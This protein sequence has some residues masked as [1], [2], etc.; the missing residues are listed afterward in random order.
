[1]HFKASTTYEQESESRGITS[2]NHR[3]ELVAC[4]LALL[5]YANTLGNG[6]CYDDNRIVASNPVVSEPGRWADVWTGDYWGSSPDGDASRDL[7]YRPVAVGS[8]RMVHSLFGASP[9]PQHLVNVLLHM[10]VTFLVVRLARRV[11]EEPGVAFFSGAVFAVLPIH[12]EAVAAVVGRADLIATLGVLLALVYHYR[13]FF[14][15]ERTNP[16]AGS[17][18]ICVA[19]FL[20]V[21]AKE[22]GLA[23][24]PLLILFDAYWHMQTH[25]APRWIHW[26]R[27]AISFRLVYL[28]VPFALYLTLRYYALGGRWMQVPPPTK[29]VNMLVDAPFW[30]HVLGVIQLWGMYLAKTFWP[31]V[32]SVKYSVNALRLA[33]SPADGLVLL[34]FA[35]G[36]LWML[37]AIRDTVRQRFALGLLG[38]AILLSY[39]PT[40]NLFVLIRVFLAERT[41]YLPSVW[42]VMAAGILVSRLIKVVP[43]TYLFGGLCVIITAC[44]VRST[45]RNGE[46]R[47]N[48]SL[49]AS[50]Y[51]DQPDGIGALYLY[52]Q[53]LFHHDDP[54]EGIALLNRTIEIDLGYTLAHRALGEAYAKTGNAK[55]A[56]YHWQTANHQVPNHAA[57]MAGLRAVAGHLR[58]A[59]RSLEGLRKSVASDPTHLERELALVKRLRELGLVDEAMSRFQQRETDF[60]SSA[61]W[62]LE[63]AVTC[64]LQNRIDEAISRYRKSLAADPQNAQAAV[65][66][67]MLLLERKGEGDL[68]EAWEWV[69]QTEHRQGTSVNILV[70]QAELLAARGDLSAAWERYKRVLELLPPGSTQRRIF[71]QRAA[72]LGRQP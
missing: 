8:Y 58:A 18:L 40:S 67:A 69:T 60:A 56:L 17:I 61:A 28:I 48:G 15:G 32:L 44:L 49:Y 24:F 1:M 21:G 6:Y 7:L 22:A 2:R 31:A 26:L 39:L 30:Q 13:V 34:G 27:G 42:L 36:L 20:A 50:A 9:F 35:G 53:W 10:I 37:L 66:L 59:D 46:W 11:S 38:A 57:T 29:T 33:T 5:C 12:T 4:L 41:W 52:G 45:I 14:R 71:E 54:Q 47:D 64:V 3:A 70:C 43:R 62:Q 19:V 72:V 23:V 51:R 55:K 68:A 16:V 65:E 25:Q 63:Y